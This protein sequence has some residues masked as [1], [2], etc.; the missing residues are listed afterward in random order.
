M[1][2]YRREVM[3][4]RLVVNYVEDLKPPIEYA[5]KITKNDVTFID[6]YFTSPHALLFPESMP[7]PVGRAHFRAFLP[8]KK[9]G[10]I[11]IHLAGTG[12]HSYF[13]REWL[14]VEDMLK[15]GIGSIIIQ[16]PF[17]GDRKPPQQFRSS[18]EN[19]SDL[20]VMG[21][22]IIA[23]TNYLFSWAAG[24]GYGPFAISGVSMGG[25]MAQLS[26]SNA[27]RP[28]VIVPILSWTTSS[29]SYTDGAIA[30]AIQWQNLQAQ[31]E[32]QH[33]LDKIK[34]IPDVDWLDR[35]HE[36][37]SENGDLPARNMM[38]ILMDYFVSLENY[39][40]PIA[41]NLAHIFLADQDMYVLRNGGTKSYQ[42]VWPGC[43]VEMM[44][45]VG[46]VTA[47]LTKHQVWRRKI[48]QLL[49]EL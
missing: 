13:R 11:C 28:T 39:P 43:H 26:G 29:P 3:S 27:H 49:R 21:A 47:Y 32:D 1:A 37:T 33:Y 12:D 4:Q 44:E 17:Y 7:G 45:N 36:M 30:P 24:L 46:H 41:P 15:D 34:Q 10:P 40:V 2:K 16:N 31:L 19:V 6:G 38:R 9:M 18:L 20:F 42:E 48:G 23:E 35:M 5:K 25:F 22:A 14:L 8:E